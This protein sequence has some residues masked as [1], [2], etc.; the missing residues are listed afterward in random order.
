[1]PELDDWTVAALLRADPD[2]DAWQRLPGVD[3][4]KTLLAHGVELMVR[5]RGKLLVRASVA[6]V[7]RDEAEALAVDR[8]ASVPEFDGLTVERLNARR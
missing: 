6:G 4:G 7:D 1:M 3:L 8:F 2:A 5:G